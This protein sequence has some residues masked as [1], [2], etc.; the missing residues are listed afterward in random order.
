M[1]DGPRGY[2]REVLSAMLEDA[3][4]RPSKDEPKPPQ[5]LVEQV[6]ATLRQQAPVFERAAQWGLS[7]QEAA[8]RIN[9][10]RWAKE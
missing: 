3:G 5:Q 8:R 2:G 10:A 6:G 7:P 9:E 4:W 1:K